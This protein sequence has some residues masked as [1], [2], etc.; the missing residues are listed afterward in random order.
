MG[1]IP[2]SLP[3]VIGVGNRDRGDDAVGPLVADA[4]ADRDD[5]D[6]FVAE[7]DLSDLVLRWERSRHVVIVDALAS[8]RRPGTVVHIDALGERL[9][10]DVGLVSSHGVGL[11][12]AIELG[13]VLDR[14]PQ[15][16]EIIG[17]EATAFGQFDEV[18]AEIAHAIPLIVER[19]ERLLDIAPEEPVQHEEVP[20]ARTVVV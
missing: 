10:I 20:H 19:I 3:L 2:S 1:V 9:P 18:T 8:G 16:L 6:T 13:R 5:V 14:L 17:V 12:E 11:A 4:F 15:R 7:G